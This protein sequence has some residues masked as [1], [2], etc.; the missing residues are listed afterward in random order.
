MAHTIKKPIGT[1]YSDYVIKEGKCYAIFEKVDNRVETVFVCN[2]KK[3]NTDWRTFNI[4]ET[5]RN[6]IID[7]GE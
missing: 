5:K 4:K 1:F 2:T 7:L 3:E 6:L